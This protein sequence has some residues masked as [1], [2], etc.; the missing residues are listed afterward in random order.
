V[1]SARKYLKFVSKCSLVLVRLGRRNYAVKR[2]RFFYQHSFFG[3][4]I[5]ASDDRIFCEGWMR[6]KGTLVV[7]DNFEALFWNLLGAGKE[8]YQVSFRI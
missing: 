7:E 6:R 3:L 5:V 8:N 1:S 2:I 4:G